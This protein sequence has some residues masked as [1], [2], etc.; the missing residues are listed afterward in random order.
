MIF[1]FVSV[2]A[3]AGLAA[4]QPA[5][6]SDPAAVVETQPGDTAPTATPTP[7][8]EPAPPAGVIVSAA[9]LV[10]EYRVPGADG[11]DIDLPHG[12]SAIIDAETIRVSASCVNFAWRYRFE[13]ERLVTEAIPAVSCERT[14]FPEEQAVQAAFDAAEAVRRLP[15]NGIEFAGGGH[16]VLLF[17]Q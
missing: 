10:G 2:A 13:G 12:V 16:S 4:C 17:S 6:S 3:V 14:L 15:S 7:T 1:R 11:Q 5:G 9:E 8:P